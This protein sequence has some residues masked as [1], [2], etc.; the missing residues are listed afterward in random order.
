MQNFSINMPKSWPSRR[1]KRP[2]EQR[3][4]F[5]SRPYQ[6]RP[7]SHPNDFLMTVSWQHLPYV[8]VVNSILPRYWLRSIPSNLPSYDCLPWPW[9]NLQQTTKVVRK[10]LT[11]KGVVMLALNIQTSFSYCSSLPFALGDWRPLVVTD[12]ST[13]SISYFRCFLVFLTLLLL[14]NN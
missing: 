6:N 5:L 8:Q 7:I 4:C 10:I 2:W 14:W 1:V 3:S 12:F 11:T 13:L 9:W